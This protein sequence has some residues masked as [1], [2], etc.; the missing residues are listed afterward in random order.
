MMLLGE[1]TPE[2]LSQAA[3]PQSSQASGDSFQALP[4]THLDSWGSDLYQNYAHG[5]LCSLF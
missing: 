3:G 5:I 2:N 1:Q 4:V